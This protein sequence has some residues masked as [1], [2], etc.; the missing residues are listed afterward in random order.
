MKYLVMPL[1]Y[2]LATIFVLS[3]TVKVV[4]AFAIPFLG[5]SN[6]IVFY[7]I[8]LAISL[9]VGGYVTATQIKTIYYIRKLIYCCIV[10]F[11]GVG[12]LSILFKTSGTLW[13]S[14]VFSIAGAGFSAIGGAM[15]YIKPTNKRSQ[16]D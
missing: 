2:G 6:F 5:E 9:M 16:S 1:I 13:F 11:I 14:I 10:G 15:T 8:G 3:V 7:L 12:F 4:F